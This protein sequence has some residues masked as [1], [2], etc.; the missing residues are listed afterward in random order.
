MG[1][2]SEVVDFSKA[3]D[4]EENGGG[5]EGGDEEVVSTPMR[6]S[7]I[8]RLNAAG[9]REMVPMQWGVPERR[10]LDLSGKRLWHA[11]AE[12]ID[13]KDTWSESFALR[14]G[15]MPVRTFNEGEEIGSK[16]KQWVITPKDG[17]PLAIAVIYE[18]W[19]HGD[20]R[21]LTFAMVTTKPN[22]LI[23]T[24]TDRM[25]A[26]LPIEHHGIWLGEDRAP[27]E[28]VKAVLQTYEDGGNWT[29]EPQVKPPSKRPPP[30]PRPKPKP[31]PKP[32]KP[33]P[34][35]EELF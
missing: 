23:A 15:I 6:M 32:K 33:T 35:Q 8:M 21:L 9:D 28:E 31:T 34:G 24:I 18:E 20:E 22:A 7:N 11:R 25:P 17:K 29:M 1:S 10:S 4:A 2:W 14:R 5:G 12:T 30:P 19:E 13:T 27:L 26:I 3:F 16:T